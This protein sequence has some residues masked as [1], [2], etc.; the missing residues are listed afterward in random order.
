MRW[1]RRA[2]MNVGGG[3]GARVTDALEAACHPRGVPNPSVYSM[4]GMHLATAGGPAL[5]GA[6]A[7]PVATSP[8]FRT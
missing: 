4:A 7:I 5:S 6:A 3:M 8:V 2:D 1:R